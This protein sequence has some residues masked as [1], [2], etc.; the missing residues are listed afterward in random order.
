MTDALMSNG[1]LDGL[2]S[3]LKRVANRRARW[4]EKPG[5]HRQRNFTAEAEEGGA[6]YRINLR[7]NTDDAHDFSC[8]LTLVRRG[9]KH[10][11]LIRYNGPSHV[12][13]KNRYGC[14]MHRA[15]AEVMF[16]GTKIDGHAEVT[17][18]YRTPEGVSACLV[19]DRGVRG[20]T[21]QY[22]EP[23]LFNDP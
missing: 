16:A 22:N 10:L 1:E 2:R 20:L 21:A 13:G 8:G 23:E 15:T 9:G 4:R 14:H 3:V 5:R 11:N 19:N 7:Q 17:Y 6:V 18:S 12:H